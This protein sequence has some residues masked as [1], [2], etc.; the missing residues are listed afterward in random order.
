MGID[1]MVMKNIAEHYK[2]QRWFCREVMEQKIFHR[3]NCLRY[4]Y[5]S[6]KFRRYRDCYADYIKIINEYINN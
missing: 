3:G 4:Y 1:L 6:G 2:L 5:D